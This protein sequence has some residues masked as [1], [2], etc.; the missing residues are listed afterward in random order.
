MSK[1]TAAVV[2]TFNRLEKLKTVL[3]K[4]HAQTT[5]PEWIVVVD[6][7]SSDGTGAF[8]AAYQ[9]RPV[10]VIRLEE[11]TGGAGGFATGMKYAYE[12]GADLFWLMDDDC[13][14]EPD[15]LEKLVIGHADAMSAMPG[16][17]PFAC[18]LVHFS[19]DEIA[20][21]NIA[22][23]DWKWARLWAKGQRAVLVQTCSFVSALY[24]RETVERIG[25]PL[26]EYFIWFD[27]AAYARTASVGIGPG[28]C[29]LD[30]KVIHDTPENVAGDFSRV[31]SRNIWKFEYG[32]RNEAS[33]FL[34]HESLISYL[35][36]F[37]RVEILMHRG[38]VPWRLRRRITGRL[39][40]AIRFNP[41][42]EHVVPA[43]AQV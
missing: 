32:A 41:Q 9:G 12:L 23:P 21:M 28:V 27:D 1:R 14:P 18:S 33:Y 19:H 38:R 8:L 2:V 36:F 43:L 40:A 35:R 30:S 6:N 39:L 3:A 13:Y 7:A 37:A 11:N 15:S 22:A 16:G 31:D 24:T 25:L 20:E 42:P 10:E 34:H 26:R 29:I 4:L 5:P 17:V